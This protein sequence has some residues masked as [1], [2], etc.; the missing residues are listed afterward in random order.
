MSV[1][2]VTP[3]KILLLGCIILDMVLHKWRRFISYF[4]T[5]A[6]SNAAEGSEGRLRLS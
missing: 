1:Y 3:F 6:H 2:L 5:Q 4:V